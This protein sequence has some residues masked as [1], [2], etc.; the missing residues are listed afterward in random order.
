MRFA[1]PVMGPLATCNGPGRRD[2]R[3]GG[4]NHRNILYGTRPI[5][6]GANSAILFSEMEDGAV[7]DSPIGPNVRK[8]LALF[9]SVEAIPAGGGFADAV[10]FFKNAEKR[11]EILEKAESKTK[12]AIQ[13]IKSAPDNPYGDDEEVIAGAILKKVEEEIEKRRP[14]FRSDLI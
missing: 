2:L 6:D 7:T 4:K 11:K 13:L 1:R 8:L 10:E 3:I 9:I 5:R 12:E 14:K